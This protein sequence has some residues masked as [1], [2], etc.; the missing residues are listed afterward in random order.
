MWI[1]LVAHLSTLWS[2]HYYV[3]SSR[4]QFPLGP[5]CALRLHMICI[6]LVTGRTWGNVYPAA[7]L[8]NQIIG[9]MPCFPTQAHY[10]DACLTS[11]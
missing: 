9:T 6:T 1:G 3:I 5:V 11:P 7:R 8:E 4:D 2:P 10:P